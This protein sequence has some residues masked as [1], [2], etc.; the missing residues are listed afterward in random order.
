MC[1]FKTLNNLDVKG[2]RVLFRVDL[3]VPMQKGE[4]TDNTRIRRILPTL[5]ELS[6]KGAKIILIS[7][8]GRPKGQ[9]IPEMSLAPVADCLS[10]LCELPVAFAKDTVNESAKKTI[11]S[12]RNGDVVMLENVRFHA[13]EEKND[14]FFA[15]KLS[16]LGDFYVSDAFSCAHRTHASIDSLPKLLP[17]AAG[18][19]MQTEVEK[20]S[21]IFDNPLSPVAAIV[22][23]AKVSTKIEVLINL[24]KK[25]DFLIIGGG[26][27][28]TFLLGQGYNIGSSLCEK[29]M[30]RLASKTIS[31]GLKSGCTIILPRDCV[32]ARELKPG[33]LFDVVKIDSVPQDFK[34]L[35]V[36]PKTIDYIVKNLRK[37]KTLVWNGPFGAFEIPPFDN[38]TNRIAQQT[39]RLTKKGKL[40]SIAGGG[41]TIAALAQAGVIDDFSYVSTAGG[42]F[43]EW[44]E[45]KRLPGVEVLRR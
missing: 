22:G 38:G 11:A 44:I 14:E 10:K 33:A 13:E 40:L 7:H 6:N 20:L 29:D 32:V 17:S 18:R 35:D 41:D 9:I 15:V 16:K 34:I 30:T 26:M 4:V 25:V 1:G 3:N 5:K 42:A 2:L 27:A 12:M 24:S 28:N 43:L 21:R 23:G 45:G 31:L 19:L 8:F 36:G 39:A 37:C